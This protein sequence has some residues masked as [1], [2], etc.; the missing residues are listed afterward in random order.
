MAGR[1][2]EDR[3][4]IKAHFVAVRLDDHEWN[5]LEEYRQRQDVMVSPAEVMRVALRI[6][7][8][9]RL[10]HKRKGRRS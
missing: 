7:L 4:T 2:R 8:G 3:S 6:F 1:P 5:A 10:N 9:E